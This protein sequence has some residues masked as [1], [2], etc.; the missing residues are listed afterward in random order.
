MNI[1]QKT[2]Q[3]TKVISGFSTVFR[4]WRASHSHCQYLHGYAVSFKLWFEG[5]LDE[6]NWVYD[7]AGMKHTRHLIDGKT[8]YDYFQWLLDHTVIVAADDPMLSHFQEMEKNQLIQLRILPHVGCERFAE[9][10]F[11]KIQDFLK[12]ETKGRVRLSKIE[13]F[14]NEKNSAIYSEEGLS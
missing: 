11:H 14:E 5:E 7:F 4:Q 1:T 2:F 8:P 10:L 9:F 13:F 6:K 12:L 3:S